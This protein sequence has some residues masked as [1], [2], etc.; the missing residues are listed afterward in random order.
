MTTEGLVEARVRG[1]G[2]WG[3]GQRVTA[4]SVAAE[5]LVEA[6]VRTW[7]AAERKGWVGGDAIIS[8][9][10]RASRRHLISHG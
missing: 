2:A 4:G 6:K 7:I 8:F 10:L 1:P 3:R 9:E 5:G